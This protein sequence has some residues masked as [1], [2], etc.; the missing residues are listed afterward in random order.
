MQP[1]S[2]QWYCKQL[3]VPHQSSVSRAVA[4]S[5]TTGLVEGD[6]C[7]QG[8]LAGLTQAHAIHLST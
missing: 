6:P 2:L 7:R 8:R 4:D 5:N 1:M 3:L